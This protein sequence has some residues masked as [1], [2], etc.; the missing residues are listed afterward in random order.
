MIECPCANLMQID[1]EVRLLRKLNREL[2]EQLDE[3]DKKLKELEG[4]LSEAYN[5][6]DS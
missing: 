1:S 4:V 3:S 2:R 6:Q 5:Q